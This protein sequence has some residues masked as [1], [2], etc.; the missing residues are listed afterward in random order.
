MESYGTINL[1][2]NLS[3]TTSI[4]TNSLWGY[5]ERVDVVETPSSIE[6]IY[7]ETSMITYSIWPAPPPQQRVF[8]IVYSCKDGKWSKSEP[9]YGKIISAQDE[10]YEFEE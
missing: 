10:Y 6:M 4:T 1:N 8:K 7:K 2:G 9:I 5:S 3:G